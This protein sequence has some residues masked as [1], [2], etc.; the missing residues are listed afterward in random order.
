MPFA[1]YEVVT[2]SVST[3]GTANQSFSVSAPAGKKVL[4]GGFDIAN[5]AIEGPRTSVPSADGGA[6]AFT[7]PNPGGQTGVGITLRVVC[8]ST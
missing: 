3:D 6:W 5:G 4:G 2:S 1:N 8:A 7:F